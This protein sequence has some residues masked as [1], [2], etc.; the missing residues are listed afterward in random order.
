MRV[1]WPQTDLFRKL[2]EVAVLKSECQQALARDIAQ[3]LSL[4]FLSI[5]YLL[6]VIRPDKRGFHDLLC[7]TVV[8]ARVVRQS[9]H[10]D[11]TDQGDRA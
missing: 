6:I 5:P 7:D 9:I 2:G 11:H 4:F 1:S 10:P 8:V 3:D